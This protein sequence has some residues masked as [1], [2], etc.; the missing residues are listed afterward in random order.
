MKLGRSIQSKSSNLNDITTSADAKHQRITKCHIELQRFGGDACTKNEAIAL[1]PVILDR[2]GA[3]TQIK[4]VRIEAVSSEQEI[5]PLTAVK[6]IVA[7]AALQHIIPLTTIQQIHANLANEK[8]G[9]P[10]EEVISGFTIKFVITEITDQLIG[11]FT[12][13]Q[14]VLS[15]TTP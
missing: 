11:S 12:P 13:E 8:R 7:T 14:L 5:I 4:S 15:R 9:I 2:V 6:I 1:C 3:T 10:E